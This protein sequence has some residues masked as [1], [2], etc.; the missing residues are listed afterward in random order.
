M[1]GIFNFKFADFYIDRVIGIIMLI[2]LNS[3]IEN[4]LSFQAH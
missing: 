3:Q 4:S 2:L 1:T